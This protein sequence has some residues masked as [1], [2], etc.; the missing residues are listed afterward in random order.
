[1]RQACLQAATGV[2]RHIL[3]VA[4][5]LIATLLG[6]WRTNNAYRAF[7]NLTRNAATQLGIEYLNRAQ[8]TD[9]G[10]K[11]LLDLSQAENHRQQL[12]PK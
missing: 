4:V 6:G 11:R 5:L 7:L 8:N 3:L 1:M 2:L 10:F 9:P 12:S